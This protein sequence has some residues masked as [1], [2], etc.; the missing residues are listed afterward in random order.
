MNFFHNACFTEIGLFILYGHFKIGPNFTWE[1]CLIDS[2]DKD[3]VIR[4]IVQ[5]DAY[6][7]VF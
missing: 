4:K 2:I 6:S 3:Y 5:P 1:S 7:F